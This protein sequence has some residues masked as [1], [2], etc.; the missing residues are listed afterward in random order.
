LQ[1]T[2]KL[3]GGPGLGKGTHV[4]KIAEAEAL[5]ARKFRAEIPGQ[6]IHHLGSPPLRRKTGGEILP[7]GPVELDG[8]L[9]ER[10]NG[11]QMGGPNPGL[12]LFEQGWVARG[13]RD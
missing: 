1:Q 9:V 7:D 3:G 8:L 11:P 10:Q 2:A 4:A 6:P 12:Q 5:H 13:D